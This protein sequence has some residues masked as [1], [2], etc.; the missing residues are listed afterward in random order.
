MLDVVLVDSLSYNESGNI[1]SLTWR[2][3]T[4]NA[5]SYNYQLVAASLSTSQV[6]NYTAASGSNS[7]AWKLDHI[8]DFFV[9]KPLNKSTETNV[10]AVS[11][12]PNKRWLAIGMSASLSK[13]SLC[14]SSYIIFYLMIRR[15]CRFGTS[16]VHQHRSMDASADTQYHHQW[17]D[18]IPFLAF[19][20]ALFGRR[21]YQ[22]WRSVVGRE[23]RMEFYFDGTAIALVTTPTQ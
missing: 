1:H 23:P 5:P 9:V 3:T 17:Q 21:W 18:S 10:R 12:S 16:L 15:G 2:R 14:L 22:L 13:R 11:F 7:S 8:L 6:W 19:K 20:Y 4:G